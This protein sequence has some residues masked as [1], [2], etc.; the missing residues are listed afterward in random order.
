MWFPFLRATETPLQTPSIAPDGKTNIAVDIGC[1]VGDDIWTKDEGQLADECLE[2]VSELIPDV[3]ERFIGSRVMRT[4]LAYPVFANEY[5][6][7]RQEFA[8][9]TGIR[10]FYSIGRNGE[11]DH[12]LLEDCY[13]RTRDQM[14]S[15]VMSD[16]RVTAEEPTP[17][18]VAT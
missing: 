7:R 6:T 12:L 13:W 1:Q 16:D 18:L 11:F 2:A 9:S 10:N 15:I 4:P 5:E 17:E 8:H 14:R 3:R